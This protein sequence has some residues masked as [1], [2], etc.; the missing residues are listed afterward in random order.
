MKRNEFSEAVRRTVGRYG[1]NLS[2]PLV[3]VSGGPDSVALLRVLLDLGAEPTVLHVE[4][5]VRGEESLEDAEFVRRLCGELDVP[6][7]VRHL[8]LGDEVANF[9]E[10][11]RRERYRVAEEVADALGLEVIA[12]GHTADD[13]A[14]T[15]LMNLAR[16]AGL[17]G[18]AGIPP[19][20]GRFVRPL[21]QRTRAEI[22]Q[23]LESLGQPY[24]TDPTNLTGKYA[25]NRVR[26]EVLP[27]LE[28]LYPGARANAA[29]AADSLR[30]DL[31]ALEE[32]ASRVV[33]R[34]GNEVILRLPELLDLPRALRRYA[35]RQAY[36]ILR[37]EAP[38][39][40]SGIVES[41]LGLPGAGEG[42]RTLDLPEGVVAA[43]RTTGELAFYVARE[44]ESG[45][46]GLEEGRF[47]FG[48]WEVEVREVGALDVGDAAREEVAYL[49]AGRGPYRVRTV[50][51]GDIMRPLGLGGTKK[52]LRAMMDRGV[53]ADVRRR[54]PVVVDDRG[55]VAW[56]FCGELGEEYKVRGAT[57]KILRLEVRELH[58]NV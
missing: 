17:R 30:E 1:M 9:Q 36:R 25:R 52:A 3:L 54:R 13:V 16:G 26:R 2:R 14:E 45:S 56:I 33:R 29:R 21:I 5:G 57:E 10:R 40:D 49:D 55:E 22:L 24:R 8:K 51:E 38:G 31:E 20:R 58:E 35:V 50:R 4:H 48:G 46:V 27:V 15:V 6:C 12:T 7:E 32:L 11:A 18:L 44:P 19:V 39:L 41:V 28:E 34:E 37:P 23:Y 43:A 47:A 53:P 42:T